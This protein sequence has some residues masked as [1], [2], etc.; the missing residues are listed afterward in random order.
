MQLD[1]YYFSL[2]IYL[3]RMSFVYTRDSRAAI[4][5]ISIPLCICPHSWYVHIYKHI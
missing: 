1:V 3:S 5:T 2:Y 4:L